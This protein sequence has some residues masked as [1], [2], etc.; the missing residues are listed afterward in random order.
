MRSC[1]SFPS[2]IQDEGLKG[3]RIALWAYLLPRQQRPAVPRKSFSKGGPIPILP[4]NNV[5]DLAPIDIRVFFRTLR[6]AMHALTLALPKFQK[7]PLPKVPLINQHFYPKYL[8]VRKIFPLDMTKNLLNWPLQK[9]CTAAKNV[10]L[11]STLAQDRTSFK[12][13]WFL[14]L[15]FDDS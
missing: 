6:L 13:V 1:Q 8:T 7:F 2:V 5:D 15:L 11:Q 4:L 10:K 14:V 3:S 9:S 12:F